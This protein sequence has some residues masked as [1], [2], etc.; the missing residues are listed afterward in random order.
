MIGFIQSKEREWASVA[1]HY[2]PISQED[3]VW[4]FSGPYP[5]KLP[6]QG[7]KLHVSATIL[8]AAEVLAAVGPVLTSAG[9]YFKGVCSLAELKKLNCGLH[10]GFSQVGKALTIYLY[11]ESE[12]WAIAPKLHSVTAHLSG[13]PIPYDVPYSGKTLVFYRYGAF[14]GQ[15]IITNDGNTIPDA[16][17]P[18]AAIPASIK[19]PFARTRSVN[20]IS[21]PGPLKSTFKAYE[22]LSQRGKGGV[23]RA[24]D[25]G[26]H[27]AQFCVIKEGRRYGETEWDGRDGRW[28][29]GH[30]RIVLDELG[31]RQIPVPRVISQFEES[32]NAY[33]V[34]EYIEGTNLQKVL[35]QEE[36][37]SLSACLYLAERIA[38]LQASIHEAGWAWRDCKPFNLILCRDGQVRPLDFE[39]GSQ[40]HSPDVLPWGT[41]GYVPPEWAYDVTNTSHVAQDLYA[42]GMTIRQIL[43]GEVPSGAESASSLKIGRRLPPGLRHLIESLVNRDPTRRP[44]AD[45]VSRELTK[46]LSPGQLLRGRAAIV[47]IAKSAPI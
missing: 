26:P 34:I 14:Q 22:A 44:P 8:S 45:V 9:L 29:I 12:L 33:L 31:L 23:Y 39:G 1:N 17:Q 30:E 42:L 27:P 43:T 47:R 35:L 16:R 46:I 11:N 13:P 20:T 21:K 28:R 10:Y 40:I 37:L 2:L 15:D 38:S 32:A 5:A 24:L 41:T 19:D 3:S 7:W 6:R 4:R 25:L 36:Q 18:H